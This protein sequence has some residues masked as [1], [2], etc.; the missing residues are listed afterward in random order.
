MNQEHRLMKEAFLEA[1][2]IL[3]NIFEVTKSPEEWYIEHMTFDELVAALY[4]LKGNIVGNE[5]A[6][7]ATEDD[8]LLNK[9][10]Y[11]QGEKI[12]G[13]ISSISEHTYIPTT[14]NI[15][16]PYKNYLSGNQT[17]LGDP[18]LISKN[19]KSGI[20]IFNV[21][22][23]ENVVDTEDADAEALNILI[24]KIAYI[25][26]QR[27]IGSMS[28]HNIGEIILD[29]NKINQVIEEGHHYPANVK[30]QLQE[31]SITPGTQSKEVT[32]D[33]QYVLSKV[34]VN[35]DNNLNSVNIKK[36]INIFGVEG[37]L[38]HTKYNISY[39]VNRAGKEGYKQQVEY[40]QP[41]NIIS[42]TPS[43]LGY[44]FKGWSTNPNATN[45]NYLPNDII[46]SNLANKGDVCLLYAVFKEE[47]LDPMTLNIS[48]SNNGILNNNNQ[49]TVTL[50]VSGGGYENSY[51]G[52][53]RTIECDDA[54]NIIKFLN[55]NDE[56]YENI[57]T[58]NKIGIFPI[59]V[60][61]TFDINGKQTISNTTAK[62][63]NSNG[64]MSGE[65]TMDH[66]DPYPISWYDSGWISD[67]KVNGCY[68]SSVS[69]SYT[70]T[71]H[72]GS[73]DCFAIFGRTSS[74]K[75]I[76]LYDLD[77]TSN[78][79]KEV[80]LTN[81]GTINMVDS[82]HKYVY[83]GPQVGNLNNGDISTSKSTSLI[84]TKTDDIRQV[85]LFAFSDHSY[86]SCFVNARFNYDMNYEFDIDLY[87]QDR[88]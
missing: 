1:K 32:P 63:M 8:L 44:K 60:T 7:N 2:D 55:E 4:R 83:V 67:N 42:S 85:R 26:G 69:Y 47:V 62:I 14:T 10:A 52:I 16:I 61:H 88:N 58:F 68:I 76:L 54:I 22:G 73:Y 5:F 36:G 79:K 11:V 82:S 74:G 12:I 53:T 43:I 66:Y 84:L 70:S 40:D 57:L 17:I 77:K 65:G 31:K 81:L 48:Y 38:E 56:Y 72:G 25:K 9:T 20:N 59:I 6:G 46:N 15:T 19:I 64:T 71:G 27:V 49:E 86:S 35:G 33:S 39:I 37:T 30:I 80:D 21:D 23:D 50:K 41:F 45:P 51:T 78:L 18:D 75:E 3:N 13:K 24:N 29:V 28:D 34:T 87:N